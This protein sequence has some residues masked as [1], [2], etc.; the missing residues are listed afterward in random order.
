MIPGI[1]AEHGSEFAC[2]PPPMPPRRA[3][4]SSEQANVCTNFAYTVAQRKRRAVSGSAPPRM[5]TA[6]PDRIGPLC[7]D[8]ENEQG[9]GPRPS[10]NQ[11]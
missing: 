9:V 7:F 11:A 2:F 5:G 3:H 10:R 8:C 6:P 4:Q 1:G